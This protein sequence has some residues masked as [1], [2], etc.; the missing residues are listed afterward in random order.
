M[1]A[2][3]RPT[4]IFANPDFCGKSLGSFLFIIICVRINLNALL[5]CFTVLVYCLITKCTFQVTYTL[6]Y[7]ELYPPQPTP[8]L[9]FFAIVR[10]LIWCYKTPR[11]SIASGRLHPQTPDP[12]LYSEPRPLS[13]SPKVGPH[14]FICVV[15]SPTDLGV[16]MGKNSGVIK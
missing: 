14:F 15:P 6:L 2:C 3:L 12:P 1:D 8:S 16:K 13:E 11:P 7:M 9:G 4:P 10:F 5:E